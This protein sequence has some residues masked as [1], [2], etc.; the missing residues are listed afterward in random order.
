MTCKIKLGYTVLNKTQNLKTGKELR[1]KRNGN[2]PKESTRNKQININLDSLVKIVGWNIVHDIGAFRLSEHIIPKSLIMGYGDVLKNNRSKLLEIGQ[3]AKE[4]GQL[5]TFHSTDL[6]FGTPNEKVYENVVS[7]LKY[8]SLVLESFN[9]EN[10]AIVAHLGAKYLQQDADTT[11]IS[12]RIKALPAFIK[13]K[14]SLEN[15]MFWSPR[16]TLDIARN[17]DVM[18]TYDCHHHRCYFKSFYQKPEDIPFNISGMKHL[19]IN[20]ILSW[21]KK[22]MPAKVHI[23]SSHGEEYS[24]MPVPD[25]MH[26]ADLIAWRDYSKL[27]EVLHAMNGDVNLMIEA[28]QVD[29]A[30]LDIHEKVKM[31]NPGWKQLNKAGLYV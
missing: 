24:M 29:L 21:R 4:N 2:L 17:C 5:L 14:L 13:D 23:S 11:I 1:R 30:V 26:H 9:Y 7:V 27:R 6:N 19:L 28:K 22:N 18:L 25:M 8:F 3:M 12:D 15:D 31:K 20:S 16:E 10:V